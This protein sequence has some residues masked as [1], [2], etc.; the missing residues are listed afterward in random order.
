MVSSGSPG[1]PQ[2]ILPDDR[3]SN[4]R[5]IPDAERYSVCQRVVQCCTDESHAGVGLTLCVPR[6]LTLKYTDQNSRMCY[7]SSEPGMRACTWVIGA[8]KDEID[9]VLVTASHHQG[10]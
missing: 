7:M 4:D 3:A 10:G 9:W 8:G 1:S 6:P 2:V 5:H